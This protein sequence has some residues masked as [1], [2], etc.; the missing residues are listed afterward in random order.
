[1]GAADPGQDGTL[2]AIA[3]EIDR[4][5]GE[6]ERF[7]EEESG[8]L[9]SLERLS[10]ERLLLEEQVRGLSLERQR[11][12]AA[13]ERSQARS[14]ELEGRLDESRLYL[15]ATL[16]EAYKLGRLRHVRLLL[17]VQDAREFGR[18]YRYLSDWSRADSRRVEGFLG[19][20]RALDATRRTL[21]NRLH[22]L[23]RLT[24]EGGERRRALE[25]NREIYVAALERLGE[26][27]EVGEQAKMELEE[28]AGRLE[29][30]VRSLPG[31]GDVPI[32]GRL[33][34]LVRFRGHLP[35]PAS[36]RVVVPFGD[37]KHPRFG[38]VVPHRGIEIEVPEGTE[39]RP[40]FGGQVSFADWFRG[41]GNTVVV[42]HGGGVL[43]VY[44][45]LRQVEVEVGQH[46]DPSAR[47]GASGSTGLLEGPS[48]Y[49]E[50]RQGGQAVDPLEWL[51]PVS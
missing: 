13:V 20:V 37:R 44:A 2:E 17:E 30:L 47:L 25:T 14:L 1:M 46:V 34:D 26:E 27:R 41:Y 29:S 45:H 8:I 39:V 22:E 9:G 12:Q 24:V 21:A 35:W 5:R 19:D 42:D 4:L 11:A 36:G 31:G 10:V 6:L 16:R 50:I 18:A 15:G 40:I 32:D 49:L 33:V 48:L 43:S 23:D 51:S 28:S 7:D 3:Q 38:T